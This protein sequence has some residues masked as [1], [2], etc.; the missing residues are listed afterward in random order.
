MTT[1]KELVKAITSRLQEISNRVFGSEQAPLNIFNIQT[2]LGCENY[3]EVF[4]GLPY[5][6]V[7]TL[8]MPGVSVAKVLSNHTEEALVNI[9]ALIDGIPEEYI[10][11]LVERYK[12]QN[13][14]IDEVRNKLH[15]EGA[16]IREKARKTLKADTVDEVDEKVMKHFIDIVKRAYA[17]IGTSVIMPRDRY[18]HLDRLSFEHILTDMLEALHEHVTYQTNDKLATK[19]KELIVEIDALRAA[20]RG[21]EIGESGIVIGQLPNVKPRP[22]FSAAGLIENGNKFDVV[23]AKPIQFK[24]SVG[25]VIPL[26]V[27]IDPT[28]IKFVSHTDGIVPLTIRN[29]PTFGTMLMLIS[30]SVDA[31]KLDADSIIGHIERV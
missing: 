18:S 16:K 6:E 19:C 11:E 9:K 2:I 10:A 27:V 3:A 7:I 24:Y 4:G 30:E 8:N 14:D 13:P 5:S 29:H 1:K 22:K 21:V 25:N 28:T 17:L 20:N 15:D 31:I 23:L 12:P 26:G